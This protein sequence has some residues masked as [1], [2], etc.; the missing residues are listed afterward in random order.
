MVNVSQ[1]TKILMRGL[2]FRNSTIFVLAVLAAIGLLGVGQAWITV[3][4]PDYDP[5]AGRV[6][7]CDSG[8]DQFGNYDEGCW[9]TNEAEMRDEGRLNVLIGSYIGILLLGSLVFKRLKPAISLESRRRQARKEFLSG[10]ITASEME[11]D[12]ERHRYF[13]LLEQWVAQEKIRY[14][15]SIAAEQEWYRNPDKPHVWRYPESELRKMYDR[16]EIT[17]DQF[18]SMKKQSDDWYELPERLRR[19][20]NEGLISDKQFRDALFSAGYDHDSWWRAWWI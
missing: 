19:E 15:H 6:E 5:R 11:S 18:E 20:F 2:V 4:N 8:I 12:L 1:R 9:N 17:L 3:P 13:A 10:K 14:K 7:N 16:K